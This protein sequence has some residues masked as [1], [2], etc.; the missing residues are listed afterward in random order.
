MT[1]PGFGG[2]LRHF[3]RINKKPQVSGK[4][5]RKPALQATPDLIYSQ[6]PTPGFGGGLEH[7]PQNPA[8][9][10]ADGSRGS[11]G[12]NQ[13]ISLVAKENNVIIPPK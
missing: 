8:V 13:S 12:L 5:R 1:T 10:S 6:L 2:G 3:A 9:I 11:L 4:H 7:F